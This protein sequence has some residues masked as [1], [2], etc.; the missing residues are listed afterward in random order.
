LGTVTAS[1]RD[2]YAVG[3]GAEHVMLGTARAGTR[4][5]SALIFHGRRV[6]LLVR[7]LE[8][9]EEYVILRVSRIH[10]LRSTVTGN[11]LA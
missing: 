9:I 10:R 8:I 11:P 2:L 5:E 1:D 4:N 6:G 3:W 7:A